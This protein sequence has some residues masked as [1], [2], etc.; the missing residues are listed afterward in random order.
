MRVDS[1]DQG[2]ATDHHFVHLGSMALRG[3]GSIMVEATTVVPEGR[4][5][6]EDMVNDTSFWKKSNCVILT[7]YV[8]VGSLG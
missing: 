6:P 3:W 7:F 8:D 1:S 4:I 2:R 5:S